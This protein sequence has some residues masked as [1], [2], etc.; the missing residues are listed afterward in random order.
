MRRDLY[1]DESHSFAENTTS[2][3][4][5]KSGRPRKVVHKKQV[6]SLLSLGFKWKK[7]AELTGVSVVTLRSNRK[8]FSDNAAVYNEI[9][10]VQLD[11]TIQEILRVSPHS[12][13]R[14]VTGALLYRGYKVKRYRIRQSLNRVNPS[15]NSMKRKIDRRIYSVQDQAI[16]GKHVYT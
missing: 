15:R 8:D 3:S 4:I 9:D 11:G 5:K 2:N 1:G 10:D 16:C 13:E 14:M 7:I 6:K 12:G